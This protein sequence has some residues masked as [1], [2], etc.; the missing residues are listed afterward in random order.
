M[1]VHLGTSCRC[2]CE[3]VHIHTQ[4]FTLQ[5]EHRTRFSY[6]HSHALY[7]MLSPIWKTALDREYA[8]ATHTH[9][10]TSSLSLSLSLS[11]SHTHT[12]RHTHTQTFTFT[13]RYQRKTS[14]HI[15]L[16]LLYRCKR[17]MFFFSNLWLQP[18]LSKWE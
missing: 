6:T 12:H 5:R 17:S 3:Y 16:C 10:L 4:T 18:L 11:L 9:T 7:G 1:C 13:G 15:T 14:K 2:L 8:K